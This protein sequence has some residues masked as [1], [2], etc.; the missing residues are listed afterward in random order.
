MSSGTPQHTKPI[1]ITRRTPSMKYRDRMIRE[2]VDPKRF[3]HVYEV[4]EKKA[5][6]LNS[7]DLQDVMSALRVRI[8]SANRGIGDHR[9]PAPNIYS[10]PSTNSGVGPRW[11]PQMCQTVR[12]P[13]SKTEQTPGPG[14]YTPKMPSTAPAFRMHHRIDDKISQETGKYPRPGPQT[15]NLPSSFGGHNAPS[16]TIK[17]RLDFLGTCSQ[18]CGPGPL[19]YNASSPFQ[20]IS[21]RSVGESPRHRGPTLPIVKPP[22]EFDKQKL[23][24]RKPKRKEDHL[25]FCINQPLLRFSRWQKNQISNIIFSAHIP[26]FPLFSTTKKQQFNFFVPQVMESSDRLALKEAQKREFEIYLRDKNL[27][28]LLEDMAFCILSQKPDDPISA[29]IQFLESGPTR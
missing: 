13:G 2:I 23:V 24:I 17:N 7:S 28:A 14:S 20:S 15:Y 19:V 3:C 11:M 4:P 26:L 22:R 18:G 21:P 10:F 9:G 25:I 16:F 27:P 1:N 29:L 12:G 8:R 5:K 6:I